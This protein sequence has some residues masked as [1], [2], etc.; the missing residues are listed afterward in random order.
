M[1]VWLYVQYVLEE[2]ISPAQLI[3]SYHILLFHL[4]P[5][6]NNTNKKTNFNHMKTLRDPVSSQLVFCQYS[7]EDLASRA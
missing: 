1:C 3:D 6:N 2:G 7:A 4:I 5:S